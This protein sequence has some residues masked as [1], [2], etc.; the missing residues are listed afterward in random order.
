MQHLKVGLL[1]AL[2]EKISHGVLVADHEQK[3]VYVN[4]AYEY[5][6]GINKQEILGRIPHLHFLTHQCAFFYKRLQVELRNL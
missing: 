1:T 6:T 3:I 5:L 2:V 4:P